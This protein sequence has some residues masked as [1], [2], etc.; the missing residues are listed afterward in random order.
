MKVLI[1]RPEPGASAT[2]E[3]LRQRGFMPVLAPCLVIRPLAPELP[4]NPA[5]LVLTSGQAIAA[6]PAG[7]RDIPAF[8]VGDAT[9][10]RLRAAGFARVESAGGNAGDLLRLVAARRLPGTHLLAVG[11]RQG[12]R[13]ASGLRAAGIET[14]RLEVYAA[15]PAHALPA[16]MLDALARGEIGTALFYSA[17]SAA[18]FARFEPQGL[19]RVTA[20][21]L[22]PA[23]AA[24]LQGLPWRAIRVALAP[25]EGDL[26]ALLN[27]A[28]NR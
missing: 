12:E 10:A 27:E 5:A 8:C 20:L 17:E 22:S 15:E 11:Q 13:L 19:A 16:A 6:L 23:V 18:A 24:A 25:N 2:A 21:A 4:L 7:W 14:Q 26:L 1:T 28:A 9:A 3:T